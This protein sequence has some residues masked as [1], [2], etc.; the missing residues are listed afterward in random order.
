MKFNLNLIIQL[1]N[2]FVAL[3]PNLV[4]PAI[5]GLEYHGE[6]LAVIALPVFVVHLVMIPYDNLLLKELAS[7]PNLGIWAC[8]RSLLIQK[9]AVANLLYCLVAIFLP[10]NSLVLQFCILNSMGL[11]SFFLTALYADNN[12]QRII[13]FLGG[14]AGSTLGVAITISA[15]DFSS[16]ILVVGMVITNVAAS[17]GAVLFLPER[18]AAGGSLDVKMTRVAKFVA[19]TS[20][21]GTLSQGIVAIGAWFLAPG[22]LSQLRIAISVAQAATTFFP[23]N[24]RTILENIVSLKSGSND[25]QEVARYLIPALLLVAMASFS[26]TSAMLVL[27]WVANLDLIPSSLDT[28]F[29]QFTTEMLI[30]APAVPLFLL[31]SILEKAVIGS[32]SEMRGMVFGLL[33]TTSVVAA[34]LLCMQF[35]T[36]GGFVAYLVSCAIVVVTASLLLG[37]DFLRVS[38]STFLLL[39]LI[40]LSAGATFIADALGS[41]AIFLASLV[42]I[43]STLAFGTYLVM[44]RWRELQWFA[45]L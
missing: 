25:K 34:S 12:K 22:S 44:S 5:F 21:L 41:G 30:M 26:L 33:A 10:S 38:L 14:F 13:W 15:L 39:A 32:I 2:V 27:L 35:L 7:E 36:A 19:T 18:M 20:S 45:R 28:L 24:Q 6:F 16:D 11:S 1:L 3:V 31:A 23:V 40:L 4:Y 42:S 43:L 8:I 9:L 17:I 29:T 37:S